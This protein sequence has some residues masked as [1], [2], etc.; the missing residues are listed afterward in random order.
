MNKSNLNRKGFFHLSACSLASKEIR[1]LAQSRN[2]EQGLVQRPWG[3]KVVFLLFHL[4]KLLS[5]STKDHKTKGVESFYSVSDFPI[6]ITTQE[7]APQACPEFNQVVI[8]F[9]L[10][11][12]F[13]E[14]KLT[15]TYGLK[16]ICY[17]HNR[18]FEF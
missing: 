15:S 18:M 4:L 17:I 3:N 16:Q 14:I 7:N 9:Q 2:L 5:Y 13:Q 12:R 11:V 8:F 6:L 1:A 10:R